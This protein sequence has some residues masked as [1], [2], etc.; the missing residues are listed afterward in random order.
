MMTQRSGLGLHAG[1][2]VPFAEADDIRMYEM[3]DPDADWLKFVLD[4]PMDSQPGELYRYTDS[5]PYVVN[6]VIRE[7]TG[8]P[9][10]QFAEE[11][12]FGPLGI[13]NYIW[14]VSPQ[15]IAWG[16][17]GLLL[18]AHDLAKIGAL[19][20]NG[21]QWD[22][23]QLLSPAWIEAAWTDYVT[24]HY[25]DGYGFYWYMYEIAG[26]TPGYAAIG[27]EGQFLW[28]YPEL[29]LIVVT[30]GDVSYQ[31][32]A[33]CD[34]YIHSAILGDTPVPANPEGTAHLEMALTAFTNPVPVE[35]TAM[36][37]FATTIDNKVYG[38]PEN[39]WGW[40]TVALNFGTGEAT[41]TLEIR[42]EQLTLPVGFDGT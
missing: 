22:G 1:V 25:L 14:A 18:S 38:L 17:D 3:R 28:V 36:P 2:E 31:S 20:M 32:K 41:L 12:L 26:V 37:E 21:G 9:V 35:V 29:N 15:G 19:Y 27:L 8:Q 11:A 33:L 30:N 42:G 16:G 4:F 23:Q 10:E 34:L 24:P 6:A 39:G 40:E 13:T 5:N 7:A